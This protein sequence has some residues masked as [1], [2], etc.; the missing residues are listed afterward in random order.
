MPQI[1][2]P[3]TL[4]LQFQN[5]RN[6]VANLK[7]S[8]G[9]FMFPNIDNAVI[10]QDTLRSEV[11]MATGTSKFHLPILNNDQQNGANSGFITEHR[12]TLQDVFI[13]SDISV[14]IAVPSG[15]NDGLFRLYTYPSPEK[16]TTAGAAASAIGMFSN[17]Y[18][19]Y[20]VNN[21]DVSPYWDLAK[22]LKIPETQYGL[23]VGYTSSGVN[24]LDSFDGVT[25]GFYPCQPSWVFNGGGNIDVSINLP[26]AMT[27]IQANSRIVAF[28]RGFLAQNASQLK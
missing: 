14:F 28:F 7:D 11:L 27:A 4:D 5:A 16:W 17:A 23:N 1:I 15:A 2:S 24:Q 12:L 8:R 3:S 9:R 21:A 26:S 20:K 22:H 25:D 18:M 6:M 19:T 10:T 13:V